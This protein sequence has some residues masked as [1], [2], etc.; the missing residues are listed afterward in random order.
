M[1]ILIVYLIQLNISFNNY[2]TRPLQEK[3]ITAGDNTQF[4]YTVPLD[5]HSPWPKFRGNALQNGRSEINPEQSDLKPW[6]FKTGKGIFSSPVIDQEG[7]VYIGSADQYFYAIDRSG[8]LKWKYLTGEIIDSSALL[9]NKGMVYVG[10][11]DAFVYAFDRV[12][13]KKVWKFKAHTPQEV[14]EKYDIKT[15]NLNW[16]EGNIA[17]LPDGS[18]IAPNDNYLIYRLN[19]NTGQSSAPYLINEMGWSLPAVN[20]RTG[21]IITGSNFMALKNVFS[22]DIESGQTEWTNGGFGTNAASVMLSSNHPDGIAILGGY[23]GILRA[24]GQKDGFQLWKF[25]TRDHIYAS[26]AQLK[27][28]TIIQ[29]S[30]DGT[31]YGINPETGLLKWAFDTKEP[32]RSSP[33]IDGNGNIYFGSGEGRLFCLNPNGT[34]R[35]SY[36]LIDD[37]RNDINGSPGLGRYGVYIAGENGSVFFIPYDYPLTETGKTDPK[38]VQGP[39]EDLPLQGEFLYYTSAFGALELTPPLEIEA[40]Q[41]L[42]FSLY[43]RVNGDT[44]K[45]TIN[46][47]SVKAEFK[48]GVKGKVDT[49]ANSQF[50]TL[51]PQETWTG[52]EGGIVTINIKGEYQK[53]LWRFGLKFFGGSHG[54]T[55]DQTFSFKVRPRSGETSPYKVPLQTGDLSSTIEISRLAPANPSILPSYN[56]IGY[57]SLHYVMGAVEADNNNIIVWGVGGKL[58]GDEQKTVIDPSL[59]VRFPMILNYDNGLVT[60]Y[61]YDG[62]L[63][64]MNGSW[65]MPIDFFRLSGKVDPKTGKQMSKI[66]MNA[67][68]ECDRIEFYGKFLKLLGMSE[69]DTGRMFIYGG[70]NFNLFGNGVTRGPVMTGTAS[71]ETSKESVSVKI[72]K[73]KLKKKNHVFSILLVSEK[74]GRPVSAKYID[75]TTVQTNENGVVTGVKLS[76]ID[77]IF[78][79]KARIYYM[80]DTYPAAKG[81]VEIQ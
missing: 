42:A 80:I 61:N 25:G 5:P 29:P 67:I 39:N 37:L 74:T 56:Q 21:K 32:I 51:I 35:W 45:T 63:L 65:D 64:D 38:S 68:V 66:S 13:G 22:F 40:N 19:R 48:G 59:E 46:R 58:L 20:S 18:V 50:I 55:F 54:G 16:F 30:T 10:S 41:P 7:T 53:D 43:V 34:L 6:R 27:D 72:E 69:I 73:G 79:G 1:A 71:F 24:F 78:N 60:L 23:D 49:S 28:G 76:L 8:N 11:G 17:M 77:N 12:T 75:S 31:V 26:P 2:V 62:I 36:Q 47:D 33:A 57:D 70:S 9:D 52:L 44:I 4:T 15:Y 81:V 3:L 14:T